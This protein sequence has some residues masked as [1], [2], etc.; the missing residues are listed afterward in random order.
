[1]IIILL[2]EWPFHDCACRSYCEIA[3]GSMFVTTFMRMV[4]KWITGMITKSY[5]LLLYV[6]TLIQ[7]SGSQIP[8]FSM[9]NTPSGVTSSNLPIHDGIPIAACL[10]PP[11]TITIDKIT[12]TSSGK[13]ICKHFNQM[14]QE[15][16]SDNR[17]P[18][19]SVREGAITSPWKSICGLRIHSLAD[20]A[21]N[22][23][24]EWNPSR[25]GIIAKV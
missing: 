22:D 8:H 2:E 24:V 21:A 10:V 11:N 12:Y 6:W 3:N 13:Q 17:C 15:R 23:K 19:W 9:G 4:W 5:W 7:P 18:R 20:M 16:I 14:H 1:M 25:T